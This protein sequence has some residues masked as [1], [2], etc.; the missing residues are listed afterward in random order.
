LHAP[1]AVV[2]SIFFAFKHSKHLRTEFDSSSVIFPTRPLENPTIDDGDISGILSQETIGALDVDEA[3]LLTK[4]L[5]P[6]I[7]HLR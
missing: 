6:I 7:D 4:K 5:P 3:E 2:K 1:Q